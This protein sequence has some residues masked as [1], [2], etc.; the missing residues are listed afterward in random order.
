MWFKFA[1]REISHHK[2][3]SLLFVLNITLG[4]CGFIALDAFKSSFSDVLMAQS[5]S[6]MGADLRV[7][8]RRF[9]DENETQAL[10]EILEG[11]PQSQMLSTYSMVAHGEV[12][13]LVQVRV[14]DRQFP[15]YGHIELDESIKAFG[16]VE[17]RLHSKPEAWIYPELLTLLGIKI[18]DSL[19]IGEMEFK[20]THVITADSS[21]GSAMSALAPRVFIA[22]EFLE[23]TELIK[24]GS[25]FNASRLYKLNAE[26]DEYEFRERVQQAIDD[27]G[28]RVQT[29]QE[30]SEQLGRIIR[31]L[32]DYLGLVALV[33]LFLAGVGASYL[34]RTYLTQRIKDLAIFRSLGVPA[35]QAQGIFVLQLA[36]LGAL[37]ALLTCIVSL[38][39]LPLLNQ[40]IESLSPVALEM[41]FKID[42]ALLALLMGV[43]VAGLIN[44]P[45]LNAIR[46]IKISSL[47]QE[48]S[49]GEGLVLNIWFYLPV[50]ILFWLLAIWQSQSWFVGSLFV[51]GLLVCMVIFV[52]L[53]WALILLSKNFKGSFSYDLG[54]RYLSRQKLSTMAVVS[55]L[56]LG[57]LLVNIIPQLQQAIAEDVAAP[58]GV[59]LP[60]L[61][62]FDIQEEQVEPLKA[63]SKEKNIHIDNLSAIVRARLLAIN[64]VDVSRSDKQGF[65]REEERAA[66]SRNRGYSL[67]YRQA[68]SSSETII[69]GVP[70]SGVYKGDFSREQ[71]AEISVEDGFAERLE[72]EL[73]DVM[74]FEV[75]GIPISG[76]IVNFREVRWNSFQP[77]F[78]VLFQEG[79]LEMAPK[80]FIASVPA[81]P[82]EQRAEVQL[83]L[84]K[85][86]SNVS[87]IDVSQVVQ[88]VMK[89]VDQMSWAMQAMA[90][91]T[92]AVGF[93]VL[94]SIA[95][96]QAQLRIWDLNL[97]KI[98]G[99][100]FNDIRLVMAWEFALVGFIAAAL[101]GGFSML[102]TLLLSYFV[103]EQLWW[104]P[105]EVPLLMLVGVV[106]LSIVVSQLAVARVLR[107]RA[108][109]LLS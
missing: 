102:M 69:E 104:P 68:L 49:R 40:S 19:R 15:F 88:R 42:S 93:M 47:L 5:R 8:A 62:L 91:L 43:V 108:Q 14:I 85:N 100:S 65:T 109:T 58:E 1:W 103:F 95:N 51:G 54:V 53:G 46:Q 72:L 29:H 99:A 32:N 101:G 98:L 44:L 56:G 87:M 45:V 18:G 21:G 63:W 84:V 2:K 48:N 33:A 59:T 41:T 3:F 35:S 80:T 24:L 12:S 22:E 11:K 57:V 71:L 96:R 106:I 82:R 20:V 39:I 13:R 26:D 38:S 74:H 37:A 89:M 94:F 6:Y 52:Y 61:F 97:L 50:A 76:R 83:D 30:A 64:E 77:N 70:F 60:S 34:F 36:M 92:L 55:A 86:F 78:F 81:M 31:Y 105:F 23:Q 27:P 17:R 75:Q 79:V 107:S 7:G 67:S 16:G 28:V 90:L 25:T 4:L 9:L 73:G 10:D 66:R